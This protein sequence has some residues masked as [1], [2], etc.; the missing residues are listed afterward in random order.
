MNKIRFILFI[1][2]VLSLSGCVGLLEAMEDSYSPYTMW[3]IEMLD[4]IRKI[5]KK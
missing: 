3:E 4:A 2:L 5:D 1:I